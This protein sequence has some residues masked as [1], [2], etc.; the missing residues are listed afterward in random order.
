MLAALLA[1]GPARSI[2]AQTIDTIIIENGNVFNGQDGAPAFVAR[3]ANA[4]HFKTRQWVI[5]RRLLLHPGD[6]F[7]AAR[8]EESERALRSLGVFRAVRVD[9]T[10]LGSGGEEGG[11]LALR[12]VSADGW[13]SQPQASYTTAGGD[14]TW[15]VGFVERN[16][17]GTATEV[18]VSYG[19]NPDRRRLDF[20]FVNP[21]FFGRRAHIELRHGSYSDGRKS[22]WRFG[23]PFTETAARR[24]VETYGE[25]V[26]E[27][28]LRFREGVLTDSTSRRLLRVGLTGGFAPYAT[29]RSYVRLWAGAEWRRE[30]FGPA[31]VTP[32]PYTTFTTVRGGIELGKIRFRVLEHFN[33]FGRREDVDLS[34]TLRLGAVV[35]SGVGYEA[36]AQ[37]AALWRRGFAVL[38]AEANGLDSTRAR[39]RL[40][41]VSQV[42]PRH[43]VVV[44][45]EGGT[46]YRPKPGAEFDLW[47]E[48]RGPRLF[49]IHDFTGTRMAWLV[50]EDRILLTD[51]IWGLLAAG[52]APFVDYGG[53]WFPADGTRMSGDV[54][55]A[56]RVGP[57]RAVRGEAAELA[58]GYRF[59]DA[60]GEGG[61]RWG[62]TLRKSVMF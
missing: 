56:L 19:R 47:M 27:R 48:Q 53:A 40:T 3:L 28:V 43:T 15:E 32:F 6:P 22:F 50:I 35:Q 45:L 61:N 5:R 62:V 13:S 38:R 23:M 49:G 39:A 52:I 11:P 34:S 54:G 58:V 44:H 21:H 33:S 30:D 37:V 20:A 7:D 8:M 24:A 16:F 31:N 2:A 60:V 57:T 51:A 10:R 25:S 26:R 42:L 9:T 55:L 46:L 18:A 29:S 14:E 4:L 36:R 1:V 59:G 41:V 17:L 12:V